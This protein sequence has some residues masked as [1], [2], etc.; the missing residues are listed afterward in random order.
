MIIKWYECMA[1]L[2]YDHTPGTD[3]IS[4]HTSHW[5]SAVGLPI[6]ALPIT[7]LSGKAI[8]SQ[9]VASQGADLVCSEILGGGPPYTRLSLYFYI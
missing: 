3:I 6:T 5:L 8:V 7:P 2:V 4:L 1:V 9:S